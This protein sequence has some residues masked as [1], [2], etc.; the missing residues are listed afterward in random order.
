[1]RIVV[2]PIGIAF[3]GLVVDSLTAILHVPEEA[4]DPIPPILARGVGEARPE[5]LLRLE[6]GRRLIAVLSPTRLFDEVSTARL[7]ADTKRLDANRTSGEREA[8]KMAEESGGNGA[9]QFVVFRLGDEHFGLPIAAV[10]EVARRPEKLTRVPRTP[11]YLEGVINLRG[12]V[13]P[14]ID[15]RRRFDASGA[16]GGPSGRIIVVDIEGVS[17]GFAVDAVTEILSVAST[18]LLAAPDLVSGGSALFDRLATVERAGRMILLIHPRALLD[19]AERDLIATLVAR[20]AAK[21][22]PRQG[23][24]A[25]G[26][27]AVL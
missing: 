22:N 17:A 10:N 4:V 12:K 1:L 13:I 8:D 18:D 19:G 23:M 7:L 5:A 9:E 11:A 20:A 14:V 27:A 21:A 16:A 25:P 26:A 15:V 24:M 2:V 6:G 3:L